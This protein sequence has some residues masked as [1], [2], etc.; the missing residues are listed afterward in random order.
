MSTGVRK[1]SMQEGDTVQAA[2][3][4]QANTVNIEELQTST[5]NVV[6]LIVSIPTAVPP[7]ASDPSRLHLSFPNQ[8]SKV[9]GP[10]APIISRMRTSLPKL[11]QSTLPILVSTNGAAPQL[12]MLRRTTSSAAVLDALTRCLNA[13]PEA[14]EGKPRMRPLDWRLEWWNACLVFR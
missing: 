14:S 4:A 8:H 7:A 10:S 12:V 13:M 1:D 9:Q 11:W 5:N 2:L 3:C 6:Y